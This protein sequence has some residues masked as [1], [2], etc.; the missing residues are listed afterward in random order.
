MSGPGHISVGPE[1]T[2]E[3][4]GK[5]AETRPYGR[6]GENVCFECGMLDEDAAKRAFALRTHG[7][8]KP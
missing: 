8:Y 4:C 2:C 1:G 7:E 5:I 3:L 6:C